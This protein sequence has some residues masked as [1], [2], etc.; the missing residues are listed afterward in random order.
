[1]TGRVDLARIPGARR[2]PRPR[3][4][5][6][7]VAGAVLVVLLV[8]FTVARSDAVTLRSCPQYE[9]LLAAHGLP[10][11][12]FSRIMYRESRCQ[13]AAVNRRSGARGLLQ[14]MP[15]HVGHWHT[16]AMT[17]AALLTPAGNVACAA[18]LYRAAG[19]SPW[20]VTR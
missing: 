19:L 18:A 8:A 17:R 14:V 1:M 20:R 12:T 11:R 10:A 2:P 13:P 6:Q 5:L 15:Q 3:I 4:R 9:R 7:L 16:C